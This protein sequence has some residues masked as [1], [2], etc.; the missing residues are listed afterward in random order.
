MDVKHFADSVASIAKEVGCDGNR[1]FGAH[2]FASS[3][4][5]EVENDAVGEYELV[6]VEPERLIGCGCWNGICLH[7]RKIGEESESWK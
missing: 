5:I 2:K 6:A 1:H 3:V 4:N 7:I